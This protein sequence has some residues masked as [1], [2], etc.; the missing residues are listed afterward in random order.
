MPCQMRPNSYT[1]SYTF[2]RETPAWDKYGGLPAFSM[3][4]MVGAK[5]LEPLTSSV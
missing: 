4:Y 1:R 5:G 3:L 2:K